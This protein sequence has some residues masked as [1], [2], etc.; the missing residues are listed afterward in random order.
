MDSP[1]VRQRDFWVQFRV[2]DEA[3]LLVIEHYALERPEDMETIMWLSSRGNRGS[4]LGGKHTEEAAVR[5]GGFTPRT[6]EV[7]YDDDC[8]G[9]DRD[10]S[11]FSPA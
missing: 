7:R 5:W 9:S 6:S 10:R 4:D 8:N 2:S 1:W 3:L 11:G